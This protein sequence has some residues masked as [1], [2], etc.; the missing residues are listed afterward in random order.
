MFEALS[1]SVRSERLAWPPS[2]AQHVCLVCKL[3]HEYSRSLL[4]SCA[5]TALRD[6]HMHVL[7]FL[8][9]CDLRIHLPLLCKHPFPLLSHQNLSSSLISSSARVLMPI[10]RTARRCLSARFCSFFITSACAQRIFSGGCIRL[11]GKQFL[12]SSGPSAWGISSCH[13]PWS[14]HV[15]VSEHGAAMLVRITHLGLRLPFK[16]LGPRQENESNSR[17]W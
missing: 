11:F 8:L 3:Q 17:L 16:V 2:I 12:W 14:L 1:R 13:R 5:L 6:L 10:A 4:P 15:F 7:S 9:V